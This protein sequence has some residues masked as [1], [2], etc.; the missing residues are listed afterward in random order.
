MD[1]DSS[2]TIVLTCLYT[3]NLLTSVERVFTFVGTVPDGDNDKRKDL[4]VQFIIWFQGIFISAL[5]EVT[6][7]SQGERDISIQYFCREVLERGPYPP[8]EGYEYFLDEHIINLLELYI[9]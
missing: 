9:D 8:W 4:L 5:H 2:L 7:N 6:G 3:I 1:T